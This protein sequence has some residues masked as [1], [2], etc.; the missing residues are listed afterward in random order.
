MKVS[1]RFASLPRGATGCSA[2]SEDGFLSYKAQLANPLRIWEENR[3]LCESTVLRLG[4]FTYG[5]AWR[6][7]SSEVS[8]SFRGAAVWLSLVILGV[9]SLITSRW[10][11]E[12][13]DNLQQWIVAGSLGCRFS[14]MFIVEPYVEA[15]VHSRSGT[16]VADR[17]KLVSGCSVSENTWSGWLGYVDAQSNGRVIG[18][19]NFINEVVHS[20]HDG[21]ELSEAALG[22]VVDVLNH[23]LQRV[24]GAQVI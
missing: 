8:R 2:E 13:P 17:Q 16:V 11:F 7:L 12:V 9:S 10:C 4:G 1:G 20:F 18:S 23:F 6:S 19:G 3:K 24:V 14:G 21:A 5:Q 22:N 15:V